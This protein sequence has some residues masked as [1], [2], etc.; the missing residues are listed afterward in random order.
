MI[1]PNEYT[2]GYVSLSNVAI[3]L[4]NRMS[5]IVDTTV[6]YFTVTKENLYSTEN[7]KMIFP[8]VG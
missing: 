8:I 6:N 1:V 5:K 2:M 4:N 3:F 7:Q